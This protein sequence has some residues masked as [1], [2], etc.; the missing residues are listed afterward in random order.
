MITIFEIR[1]FV[2]SFGSIAT[3]RSTIKLA[4]QKSKQIHK[5]YLSSVKR[6][7]DD[8]VDNKLGYKK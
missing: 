7:V 5:I 1:R 3:K 6:Y 4:P 8:K 2:T